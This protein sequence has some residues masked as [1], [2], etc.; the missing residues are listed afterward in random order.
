LI[1]FNGGG[2]CQGSSLDETI[3]DCYNRSKGKFGSSNGWPDTMEGEGYLSTNSSISNF[4][5]W[6]KIIIGYC[7][8]SLHQGYRKVPIS[9]KGEKLY[10]RGAVNTRSHFKWIMNKFP[11]FKNSN[12]IVVTGVS[13]GGMASFYWTN[14]VRSL[15]N[16]ASNVVTIIDSGAFIISKTYQTNED[17]LL[18]G[19]VNMF[20][21][22]NI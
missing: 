1:F 2:L 12:Q 21:L 4:S 16:N 10:F 8:G 22:A 6:N 9:Y 11:L 15:V 14:Y 5:S 13:A 18:T 17:F 7:D 3:A 19:F 20:K